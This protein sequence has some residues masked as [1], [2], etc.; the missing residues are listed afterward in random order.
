MSRHS[1]L[2][3]LIGSA[4]ILFL[5]A[6]SDSS[7]VE[8][9]P[10]SPYATV[11]RGRIDVEGGLIAI[12][13]PRDGIIRKLGV[14]EGQSVRQ[15]EE[16]LLL[17]VTESQLAL[18]R[19]LAGVRQAQ[20]HLHLLQQ[21]QTAASV[22]A[23][24]LLAAARAGAGEAQAA[25]DAA[26]AAAQLIAETS[27]AAAELAG[28]EAATQSARYEISLRTVRSPSAGTVVQ[29]NAQIGGTTRNATGSLLTLLPDAPRIVRAELN[30]TYIGLVSPGMTAQVS[31]ED[32]NKQVWNAK[33]SRISAIVTSSQLEDDPQR[34]SAA[35]TVEC[36]LSLDP[37]SDLRVGQR[38]LVRFIRPETAAKG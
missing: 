1:A 9:I 8:P 34:R 11:A 35:R 37:A 5:G 31:A 12:E 2:R 27:V 38:V 14:R 18:T 24:R 16:L 32:D 33:V 21:Q 7:P 26:A 10:L 22:R 17:D 20:A 23:E 4:L 29:I 36:V 30:E 25:D 3:Y 19:A 28:A 6:C 15:A 13:S